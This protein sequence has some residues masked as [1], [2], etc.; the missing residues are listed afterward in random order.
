MKYF[1]LPLLAEVLNVCLIGVLVLPL[2]IQ[3]L[4]L[5]G[6]F[7]WEWCNAQISFG[8]ACFV[9]K[10]HHFLGMC[11]SHFNQYIHTEMEHGAE[12]WW[13]YFHFIYNHTMSCFYKLCFFILFF[14]IVSW[15]HFHSQASVTHPYSQAHLWPSL[16]ST[17]QFWGT[18]KPFQKPSIFSTLSRNTQLQGW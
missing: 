18:M 11:N 13:M 5:N 8:G 9:W 17:V 12:L 1:S 14:Q 15:A 16:A 3:V 2:C 6:A 10:C 7:S 4:Q